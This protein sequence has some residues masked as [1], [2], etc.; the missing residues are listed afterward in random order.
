MSDPAKTDTRP[1][2][3]GNGAPAD[4]TAKLQEPPTAAPAGAGEIGSSLDGLRG[5]LA[6]LD[7]IVGIRARVG[8][9]LLAI[10]IGTAAAAAYLAIDTRSDGASEQQLQELRRVLG[11]QMD[12]ASEQAGGVRSEV[13]RLRARLRELSR[14]ATAAPGARTQQPS[15]SESKPGKEAAQ[16]PGTKAPQRPAKKAEKE[17]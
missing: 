17:P 9:V 3:A 14:Q 2:P 5:W 13:A 6:E 10:G 8:L 1:A 11:T 12:A 15:P 16:A 7:R 4:Q